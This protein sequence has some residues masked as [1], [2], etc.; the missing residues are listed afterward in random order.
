MPNMRP[1]F[2]RHAFRLQVVANAKQRQA[3][4]QHKQ[5]KDQ[6]PA[7]P[8]HLLPAAC[9]MAHRTWADLLCS[10]GM[11]VTSCWQPMA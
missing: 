4:K 11:L 3:R 9:Q 10:A 2:E 7:L 5:C 1:V 8:C 6:G